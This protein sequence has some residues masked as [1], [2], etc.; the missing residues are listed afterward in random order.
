M[1]QPK[2]GREDIAMAPRRTALGTDCRGL[3]T[4]Q[5]QTTTDLS[6]KGLP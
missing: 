4:K 3:S 1:K 2:E 6:L 5:M